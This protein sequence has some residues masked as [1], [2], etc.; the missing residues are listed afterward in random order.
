MNYALGYVLPDGTPTVE[1][2]PIK[3]P[4]TI[5]LYILASAGIIFAL[6]CLFFNVIFRNRK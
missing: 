3:L 4:V 2:I 6:F 1:L 5:T